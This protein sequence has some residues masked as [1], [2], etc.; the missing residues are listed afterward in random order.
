MR[1]AELHTKLNWTEIKFKS[2][3]AT[4]YDNLLRNTIVL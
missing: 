3:K 4:R 2:P 1:D